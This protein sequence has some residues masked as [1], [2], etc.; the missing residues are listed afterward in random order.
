[1]NHLRTDIFR[2][3][4]RA[5]GIPYTTGYTVG[6]ERRRINQENV[7]AVFPKDGSAIGSVTFEEDEYGIHVEDAITTKQAIALAKAIFGED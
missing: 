5:L 1:M 2:S 7:T 3:N 6:K 4:L